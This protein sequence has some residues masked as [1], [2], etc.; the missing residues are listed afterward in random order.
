[1]RKNIKALLILFY[2]FIFQWSYSQQDIIHDIQNKIAITNS[3]SENYY[4]YNA[5]LADATRFVDLDKS[6]LLINE[7]VQQKK[8]TTSIK[9]EIEILKIAAN[10]YRNAYQFVAMNDAIEKLQNLAL[11]TKNNEDL[12]YAYYYKAKGLSALDD[13]SA[14]SYIFKSLKFA[15]KTT[16][17]LLLSKVYYEIYGFYA[18]KGNLILENKYASYCLKTALKANDPQ[19]LTLAWQAKG[20]YLSDL[21]K[22]KKPKIDS[23]LI[24]FRKGISV[25]NN[26]KEKIIIQNQLGVL[27]LN[28]AVH[29][30]LFHMPVYKDSVETYANLAL[31]NALATNNEDVIINCNGLLSEM[32]YMENNLPKVENLLLESQQKIESNKVRQPQLLSKIYFALAQ[33]YKKK[34]DISQALSYYELYIDNYTLYLEENNQKNSQ[35]LDA[36]YEL[37]KKKELIKLLDEKQKAT[38]KQKYLS[39]GIAIALFVSLVLL[40]VSYNYKLKYSIQQQKLLEIKTHESSLKAELLE[41]K[42]KLKTEEASRLATEQKLILAQKNQL[43]K[44]LLAES[45]QVEH[46]NGVLQNMKDKIVAEKLDAKT[47][48]N[49]SR[50][51]NEEI[52]LDKDFEIIKNDIKEINPEF[53]EALQKQSNYKLTQLDIKYC[54]YIKL[55]LSTKQMSNLLHVEPSSIRMN[56]YR[57]KIKLNLNKDQDMTLFLNGL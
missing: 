2:F 18:N 28:T 41:E 48:Q 44:E 27:Q 40:F 38:T 24:A 51:I 1:M 7:A 5:Q 15:E 12:A 9:N 56:K 4:L 16:N 42:A 53:I 54:S 50:I 43:Q 34:N 11:K 25:F 32:A 23:T 55:N 39:I 26:N 3:G 20:T 57:L 52:R 31:K 33:L 6:V 36:K 49:L 13:S 37:T 17:Y 47:I 21:R 14:L 22:K 8:V 29:F 35:L 45:L 30:Y 19:Q 10:I 46:K